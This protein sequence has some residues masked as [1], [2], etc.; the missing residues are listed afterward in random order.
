MK[1]STCMALLDDE[2]MEVFFLT[3]EIVEKLPIVG[4]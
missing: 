3:V 1:S 2:R 4:G